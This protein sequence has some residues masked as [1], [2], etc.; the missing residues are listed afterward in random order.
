MKPLSRRGFLGGCA[1]A[2]ASL[3][4]LGRIA[5]A[6]TGGKNLIVVL[7]SGGWDVSYALDPK[8]GNPNVDSPDGQVRMYGNLPIWASAERPNVHQFFEDFGSI[9]AVVNGISISSI[10]HPECRKR[11]LT[12]TTRETN[13]DLGAIVGAELGADLAVPYFILG[14]NAF[15][16]TLSESSGRAGVTNQLV[17]LLDDS[18]GFPNLSP[19]PRFDIKSE[20]EA[21][22]QA[23]LGNRINAERALRGARGL[24]RSRLD[25][26]TASLEKADQLR[27]FRPVFGERSVQVSIGDQLGLA[28]SL[29]EGGVS[30]AVIAEDGGWDTHIGN[31]A[32]GARH[33]RLYSALHDLGTDLMRKDLLDDTVVAVI[34]EMSRTPKLNAEMGKDHWPYTSALIFGGPVAGGRAYGATN[35][36]V[37]GVETDLATGEPSSGGSIIRHENLVAGILAT[38]GADPAAWLPRATPLTALVG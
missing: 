23:Y 34:S 31:A 22:V 3:P 8:P 19:H 1:A 36:L 10:A 2:L 9:S 14:S 15:T 13:P 26:M 32:Q 18:A 27:G 17:A 29:I 38:C 30:R 7:A 20:E 4:L 33:E 11:V 28:A 24:N 12:G 21:L 16:G 5:Q 37:E 25:D 35:E 6:Q